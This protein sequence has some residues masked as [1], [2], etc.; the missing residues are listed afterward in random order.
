MLRIGLT[1]GIGSGKSTVARLFAQLGV[2]VVDTDEIAHALTAPGRPAVDE[3]V[4]VFGPTVRGATGALDRA[5]LRDLVFRNRS[6]RLLLESILHPLIRH[7]VER[8]LEVLGAPYAIIVAP[9]LIESG[10]TTLVDRTLVVDSSEE[11]QIRRVQL[12]NGLAE[13]EIR[14]ILAAQLGRSARLAQADDVIVNDADMAHLVREV[15]RLDHAYRQAVA[16]AAR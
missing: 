10:F 6:Q 4:R 15:Q 12:R 8:R 1:G 16:S 11:D 2:P 3:I 9:L 13:P 5:A 14:R 7:E